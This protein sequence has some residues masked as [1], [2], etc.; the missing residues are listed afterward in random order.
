VVEQLPSKPSKCEALSLRPITTKKKKKKKIKKDRTQQSGSPTSN[1][2][3][4]NLFWV[5]FNRFWAYMALSEVT[6]KIQSALTLPPSQTH[7]AQ[8]LRSQTW[9]CKRILTSPYFEDAKTGSWGCWRIC[10]SWKAPMLWI[11]THLC[12]KSISI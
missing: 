4:W 10:E 9:P 8:I 3:Y 12:N 11:N 2:L 5:N 1:S 6:E 7:Q